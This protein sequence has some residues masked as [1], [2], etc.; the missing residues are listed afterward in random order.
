MTRK[1]RIANPPK[2]DLKSNVQ[3]PDARYF[4]GVY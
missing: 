4:G 3:E 1:R 2:P